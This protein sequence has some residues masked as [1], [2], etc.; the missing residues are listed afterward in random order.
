MKFHDAR[1]R[2]RLAR[3]LIPCALGCGVF[4]GRAADFFPHTV[5]TIAECAAGRVSAP[6]DAGAESQGSRDA[7][8]EAVPPEIVPDP[9]LDPPEI[10][11]D[12]ELDSPALVA[13]PELDLPELD[14]ELDPA[15]HEP[16]AGRA[17]EVEL[18]P[19]AGR[20]PGRPPPSPRR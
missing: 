7:E 18:G 16:D 11:P 19:D 8:P 15:E 12:P 5:Q 4:D 20:G 2:W 14:P 3:A 10:V 9:E 6:C 17:P 13:D 1:S